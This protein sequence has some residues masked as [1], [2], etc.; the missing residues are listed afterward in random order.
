MSMLKQIMT[1]VFIFLAFG[2][3]LTLDKPDAG[4]KVV[5]SLARMSPIILI[6]LVLYLVVSGVRKI[7]KRL[8]G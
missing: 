4:G 8:Q 1:G 3:V 2:V 5:S 6:V 7:L